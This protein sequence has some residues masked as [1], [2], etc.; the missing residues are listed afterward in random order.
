LHVPITQAQCHHFISVLL[1]VWLGFTHLCGNYTALCVCRASAAAAAAAV[2]GDDIRCCPT[3][4][5]ANEQ[6]HVLLALLLVL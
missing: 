2:A 6:Q 4:N 1:C 3:G 5:N